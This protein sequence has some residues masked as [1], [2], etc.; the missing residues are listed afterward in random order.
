MPPTARASLQAAA[1]PGC[2]ASS[3]L[4]RDDPAS[5]EMAEAL[6]SAAARAELELSPIEVYRA[7]HARLSRRRWRRRV[8]AQA[9][10][11]IAFGDARDAADMVK[12]FKR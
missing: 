5:R 10:A 8:A 12:T 3:S 9:E 11:W 2:A 4:A 7:R 6:R 1:K